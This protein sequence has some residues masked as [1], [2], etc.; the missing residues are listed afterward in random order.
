MYF[1]YWLFKELVKL[2]IPI[3]YLC[4]NRPGGISDVSANSK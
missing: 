4:H 3:L 2:D 1:K